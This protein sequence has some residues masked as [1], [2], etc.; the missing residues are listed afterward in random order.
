MTHFAE[1]NGVGLGLRRSLISQL[2]APGGCDGIDFFELAPENW[3]NLG[4]RYADRLK[5]F[6]DRFPMVCHGLSLNLG[7]Q[8]PLDFKLLADVKAFLRLHNVKCYSE[9]LSFCGHGG[10]LYDLLPIP[11]TEEAVTHVADRIRVVQD[12]LEQPIAVENISYYLA[13]S[14][15]LSEI[16][17]VNAVLREANCRL[18]LDIN[19]VYVNSVNHCYDPIDFIAQLP[20]ERIAYAHIAGHADEAEDLKVDTHGAPLIK[21]V[22]DLAQTCYRRFGAIPTVLERDFNFPPLAELK[23]EVSDVKRV[24]ERALVELS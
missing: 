18:M 5:W 19:N 4:G 2:Q 9:H 16:E 14:Q 6:S 24:Q 12:Y 8:D 3:I 20:N 23:Q 1:V 15:E 17:F 10:L 21:P 22:L 13:P 11:F 7:G